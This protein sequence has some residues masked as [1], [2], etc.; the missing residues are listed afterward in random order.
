MKKYIIGFILGAITFLPI[1]SYGYINLAEKLSGRIL[2]AV[3]SHGEAYYVN[4]VDNKRYYLKDGEAAYNLMREMGLGITNEDLE[5]IEIG[6]TQKEIEKEVLEIDVEKKETPV[7]KKDDNFGLNDYI[8]DVVHIV[9]FGE[10]GKVLNYGSGI[11]HHQ[12]KRF[13]HF[14]VSHHNNPS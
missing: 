7:N 10:T 14:L 12:D 4:P 1:A 8:E 6:K 3:E 11:L 5:E 9:C 2:L 13:L